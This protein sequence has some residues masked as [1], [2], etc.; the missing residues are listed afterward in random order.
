MIVGLGGVLLFKLFP[1]D[2]EFCSCFIIEFCSDE[3]T[4]SFCEVVTSGSFSATVRHINEL[5]CERKFAPTYFYPCRLHSS[6]GSHHI[7]VLS[8]GNLC[9]LQ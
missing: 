2:D 1:T 5:R 8:A 9:N 7:F 6:D 3:K 4:F